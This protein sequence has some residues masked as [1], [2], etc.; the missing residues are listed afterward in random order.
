MCVEDSQ[1]FDITHYYTVFPDKTV[2]HR[3]MIDPSKHE[4]QRR[5]KWRERREFF[6]IVSQSRDHVKI[7][8]V[9][10]ENVD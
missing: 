10:L 9:A 6:R 4:E 7:G 3:S 1:G 5:V 8:P 2:E